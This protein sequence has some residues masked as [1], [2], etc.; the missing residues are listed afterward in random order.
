VT[1]YALWVRGWSAVNAATRQPVP[2]ED[3]INFDLQWKPKRGFFKDFW[4]RLRYAH[5]YQR[6]INHASL[7][8]FRLIVNY[9]FPVL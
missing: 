2:N 6:G 9:H 8:D 5:A 3:E 1:A 4:F 7:D